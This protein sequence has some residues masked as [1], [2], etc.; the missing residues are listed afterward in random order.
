MPGVVVGVRPSSLRVCRGVLRQ[1]HPASRDCFEFGGVLQDLS[2]GT[3][4]RY[5]VERL[6]A[7]QPKRCDEA[8][9]GRNLPTDRKP[10]TVADEL[11]LVLHRHLPRCRHRT[12][13]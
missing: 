2:S 10:L 6:I 1:L 12:P 7:G 8:L 11:Q 5:E 4:G 13:P 9:Y 3:E